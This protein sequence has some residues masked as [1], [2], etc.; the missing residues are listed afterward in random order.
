ML[1]L[2]KKSIN[3]VYGYSQDEQGVGLLTTMVIAAVLLALGMTFYM[4]GSLETHLVEG[5]ADASQAFYDAE[6]AFQYAMQRIKITGV[7]S[8]GWGPLTVDLDSEINSG[9][10]E[11]KV[12]CWDNMSP[13][14]DD[15][16][17]IVSQSTVSGETR[18]VVAKIRMLFKFRNVD[19]VAAFYGPER[20]QGNVTIDGRNHHMGNL[21]RSGDQGGYNGTETYNSG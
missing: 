3:H 13:C 14:I 12:E 9:S 19:S 16:W 11:V 7:G 21:D 8:D 5:T 2:I 10:A 4:K 20:I 6:S 18:T 1:A 17:R 15:T